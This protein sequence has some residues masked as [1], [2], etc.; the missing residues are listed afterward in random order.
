M[1]KSQ[2]IEDIRKRLERRGEHVTTVPFTALQQ[3][4]Q[5]FVIFLH[6]EPLIAELLNTLKLRHPNAA[7]GYK[8][9][10]F[11]DATFPNFTTEEG[12]VAFAYQLLLAISTENEGVKA[13]CNKLQHHF[14]PNDN[15][16]TAT[17]LDRRASTFNSTVVKPFLSTLMNC[18]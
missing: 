11:Q 4:I 6:S 13:I 18:S 3:A 2:N 16:V 8:N 5:Q 12:L 14:V 10:R 7:M 9:W 15:D 1:I 17:G